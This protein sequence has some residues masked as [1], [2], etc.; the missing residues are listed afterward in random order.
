MNSLSERERILMLM[1]RG[2]GAVI[3]SR[4]YRKGKNIFNDTLKKIK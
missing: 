4:S 1:M 2:W 3:G